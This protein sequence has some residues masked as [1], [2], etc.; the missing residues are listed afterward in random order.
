MTVQLDLLLTRKL[1]YV[2]YCASVEV[3][4]FSFDIFTLQCVG[5]RYPFLGNVREN[6]LKMYSL[7]KYLS[8][9]LKIRQALYI[10]AELVWNF[11]YTW[12]KGL[13]SSELKK[14]VYLLIIIL[15]LR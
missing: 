6:D 5:S 13:C 12:E 7:K 10:L 8:L 1:S 15:W 4:Y 11:S 2:I 3:A 9:P 14:G